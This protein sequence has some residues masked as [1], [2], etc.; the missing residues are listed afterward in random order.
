MLVSKSKIG[1]TKSV[2]VINF[3][4]DHQQYNFILHPEASLLL[5]TH[6]KKGTEHERGTEV[7]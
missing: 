3:E 5:I 1:D 4:P 7:R 2:F 6:P